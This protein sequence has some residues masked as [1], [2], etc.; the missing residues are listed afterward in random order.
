MVWSNTYSE[1]CPEVTL[2]PLMTSCVRDYKGH[3]LVQT[4]FTEPPNSVVCYWQGWTHCTRWTKKKKEKHTH[5]HTQTHKHAHTQ[6]VPQKWYGNILYS[7]HTTPTHTGTH[8]V[9]PSF[10]SLHVGSS[11]SLIS[12]KK[13]NQ[14]KLGAWFLHKSQLLKILTD[15]PCVWSLQANNGFPDNKVIS[16]ELKQKTELQKY[17]KKVMPFVQVAKVSCGWSSYPACW[18]VGG[19]EFGAPG[20]LVPSGVWEEW[21]VG[22]VGC[23]VSSGVWG[24]G[25]SG[26]QWSLG[27]MECWGGGLPGAKWSL[28]GME[29]WGTQ[30]CLPFRSLRKIS[31]QTPWTMAFRRHG[32]TFCWLAES[33]RFFFPLR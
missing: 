28:G 7:L 30:T 12:L 9:E 11:G 33:A 6:N 24:G 32:Q 4:S 23:L 19:M 3:S 27:G 22:V 14:N 5:T 15:A 21:S 20:C 29:C 17:M 10:G 8:T 26:A 1:I 18:S 16:A 13:A 25:L 31:G 2:R